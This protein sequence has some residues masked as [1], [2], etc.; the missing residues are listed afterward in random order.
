MRW[1]LSTCG[2]VLTLL[3]C[4][5]HGKPG[6]HVTEERRE[7][8]QKTS[9]VIDSPII[10]HGD[11]DAHSFS[12]SSGALSSSW[13]RSHMDE[14]R[15]MADRLRSEYNIRAH[16][17]AGGRSGYHAR[18]EFSSGSTFDFPSFAGK[19]KEELDMITRQMTEKMIADMKSGKLLYSQIAQPN[20]FESQA[21]QQLESMSQSRD[22][23]SQQQQTEDVQQQS[24][25]VFGAE[26][27]RQVPQTIGGGGYHRTSEKKHFEYTS[28]S[29]G[30]YQPIPTYATEVEDLNRREEQS[31]VAYP[32]TVTIIGGKR[33]V[34]KKNCSTSSSTH[35]SRSPFYT[36]YRTR[37]SQDI[38][39]ILDH[40]RT[41]PIVVDQSQSSYNKEDSTYS[42]Q[43]EQQAVPVYPGSYFTDDHYDSQLS[44]SVDQNIPAQ[45]QVQ[46]QTT[47]TRESSQ[48]NRHYRPIPVGGTSQ[49]ITSSSTTVRE[50]ENQRIPVVIPSQQTIT[51]SSESFSQT[52]SQRQIPVVYPSSSSTHRESSSYESTR[53]HQAIPRP[54]S[55]TSRHSI[56]KHL[57][58]ETDTVPDYKPVV[59][60]DSQTIESM[61]QELNKYYSQKPSTI[62]QTS[63]SQRVEED[64][65]LQQ[66]VVIPE[67]TLTIHEQ[68]A[69]DKLRNYN[70]Q[71]TQPTVSTS[72]QTITDDRQQSSIQY[73]PS[74]PAY[75]SQ[76]NRND[77]EFHERYESRYPQ[78]VATGSTFE[79]QEEDHYTS[80]NQQQVPIFGQTSQNVEEMSTS[81]TYRTREQQTPVVVGGSTSYQESH[82]EHYTDERQK[83][84][85]QTYQTSEET[86]QTGQTTTHHRNR[87]V[88]VSG[89]SSQTIDVEDQTRES[90]QYQQYPQS[91]RTT[92]TTSEKEETQTSQTQYHGSSQHTVHSEDETRDSTRY[93]QH[94]VGHQN[95]QV[96]SETEDSYWTRHHS[97]PQGSRTSQT[98]T[99][100]EYSESSRT[101]YPQGGHL[102]SQSTEE[103]ELQ[104]E[105]IHRRPGQV[106]YTVTSQVNETSSSS[107]TGT[108]A[109]TQHPVVVATSQEAAGSEE[110][111]QVL[112]QTGYGGASAEINSSS[113]EVHREGG[114]YPAGSDR[115][116]QQASYE[117][118]T[119]HAQKPYGGGMRLEH[120]EYGSQVNRNMTAG[121]G[122]IG[123][124]T[125]QLT[126]EQQEEEWRR[127]QEERRRQ[128]LLSTGIFEESSLN[129]TSSYGGNGQVQIDIAKQGVYDGDEDRL[130]N[131]T[132][133]LDKS[134]YGTSADLSS[135]S[136]SG[137]APGKIISKD[138]GDQP[139]QHFEEDYDMN[140][141][142]PGIGYYPSEPQIAN[143]HVPASTT[144][145]YSPPYRAPLAPFDSDKEKLINSQQT[146]V[147]VVPTVAGETEVQRSYHR[148]KTTITQTI[149]VLLGPNG[150]VIQGSGSAAVTS[151]AQQQGNYQVSSSGGYQS[152]V[153]GGA[154]TGESLTQQQQ[155][156]DQI[157]QS[158]S[159]SH[160]SAGGRVGYGS[161]GSLTQQEQNQDQTY[162]SQSSS[163]QS[164]GGRESY[165]SLAH[166]SLTGENLIQ[167][168]QNQDQ[169]YQSQSSSHQPAGGRGSY[170]SSVYGSEAHYSNKP[171]SSY[172]GS[173]Q[174]RYTSGSSSSSVSFQSGGS[175]SHANAYGHQ[176][177]E[178]AEDGGQQLQV[179]VF[180]VDGGQQT[181]DLTQQF[182][183][184][185]QESQNLQQEL[186]DLRQR[187]ES[188]SHA[189]YSQSADGSAHGQQAE[190]QSG[191]YQSHSSYSSSSSHAGSSS[192]SHDGS[193]SSSS[194]ANA[195]ATPAVA[196]QTES[197]QNQEKPGFWRR[198][199]KKAKDLFG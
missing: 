190:G 90:T 74:Y 75:G 4:T 123:Y 149:P 100:T 33:Y 133:H 137:T 76:I 10:F 29:H 126:I 101:R 170:G 18:H 48:Y 34:T 153:S 155:S 144:P 117:Y 91:H 37:T 163:Q 49:T 194:S 158:Q 14:I 129:R 176:Q 99:E 165:G 96:T 81:E 196:Q 113:V 39:K 128:Q 69:A 173:G 25:D 167:E 61:N 140:E 179:G 191:Y 84:V 36:N 16:A 82:E 131:G 55:S 136:T 59:N 21:A 116:R 143:Q 92:Q 65:Q 148:K 9:K 192:S 46:G 1:S 118:E 187:E 89:A 26:D 22:F 139:P 184:E 186:D 122:N 150:E 127:Q 27:F 43:Q 52:D 56:Y 79:K 119:H 178:D 154:V 111:T 188:E 120:T 31:S 105:S 42:K 112:V 67:I 41:V 87:P 161:H 73:R 146:T 199:G 168:Q 72:Q 47:E 160:Q 23:T 121:G 53:E 12:S 35:G 66:S 13:A 2:V 32:T 195:E 151:G 5:A 70:V 107:S 141:A 15:K 57:Q 110:D 171:S 147:E 78:Q 172:A 124:V 132:L 130:R 164:A 156:Q 85:P 7:Y 104:S 125:H 11:G 159:S 3:A 54:T 189:S 38:Q 181:E 193:S 102:T 88:Y 177:E 162:Q 142:E 166:G 157:Y 94:P 95:T 198:I 185:G 62:A 6:G 98:E 108:T 86:S 93:T 28:S 138:R 19:S 115:S 45:S 183:D 64:R 134:Q 8:Y 109:E 51:S 182:V 40:G 145:K 174:S 197:E 60:I 44:Q 80:Q 152:Q 169:I 68:E 24:Q 114:Q 180:E 83:Q 17:G 50:R 77:T 135:T 106:G 30:G 175:F 103:Q 63:E 71:P 97:R 20:Y 58:K